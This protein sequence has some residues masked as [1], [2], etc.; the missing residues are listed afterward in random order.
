MTGLERRQRLLDFFDTHVFRPILQAS[1][2]RVDRREAIE[3]AQCRTERRRSQY[4][5]CATAEELYAQFFADVDSSSEK[6]DRELDRVGLPTLAI[7]R[8][9]FLALCHELG[10]GTSERPAAAETR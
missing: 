2:D 3:D 4:Q 8:G 5:A 7:L 9:Q 10:L 1:L 6:L